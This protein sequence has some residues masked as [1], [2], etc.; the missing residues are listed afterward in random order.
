MLL[1]LAGWQLHLLVRQA[2]RFWLLVAGYWLLL[3][4][5]PM[6]GGVPGGSG[7]SGQ[8]APFHRTR[9]TGKFGQQDCDS[10]GPLQL[11]FV[12]VSPFAPACLRRGD[13]TCCT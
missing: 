12:P 2:A 7:K 5:D 1:R 8:S 3:A 6:V 13:A 11:L 10:F 9:H 4:L